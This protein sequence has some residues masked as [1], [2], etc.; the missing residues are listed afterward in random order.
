[1]MF[2]LEIR[3]VK[4]LWAIETRQQNGIFAFVKKVSFDLQA[5][6]RVAKIVGAKLKI[7]GTLLKRDLFMRRGCPFTDNPISERSVRP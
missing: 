2:R 1:M 6:P 7:P 4:Q 3:N 5:K